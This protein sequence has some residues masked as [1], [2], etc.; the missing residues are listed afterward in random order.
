[1]WYSVRCHFYHPPELVGQ[2]LY[3]ERITLWRAT[4][5]DRAIELAEVEVAEYA[6]DT[7]ARYLRACT[8]YDL[9]ETGFAVE[10]REVFSEMRASELD[11]DAYLS[12]YFFTGSERA[13]D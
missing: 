5:F 4:G 11:P 10:G 7:G 8:V 2:A 12:R 3:E 1:M 13:R 9:F 6:V